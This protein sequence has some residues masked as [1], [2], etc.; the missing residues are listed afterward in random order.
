MKKTV[1]CIENKSFYVEVEVPDNTPEDEIED[2]AEELASEADER[3]IINPHT[4]YS[5]V[6]LEEDEK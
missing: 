3:D 5:Y 4:E 2:V 6:V 1:L